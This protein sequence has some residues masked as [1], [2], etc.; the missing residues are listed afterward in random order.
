MSWHKIAYSSQLKLCSGGSQ[1]PT[2]QKIRFS[3]R[4]S[5]HFGKPYLQTILTLHE[6]F[7]QV[8]YRCYLIKMWLCVSYWQCQSILW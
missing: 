4:N 2:L 3:L 6:A 1:Y 5:I 8:R 7:G